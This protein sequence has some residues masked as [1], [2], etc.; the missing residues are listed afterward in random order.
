MHIIILDAQHTI[1]FLYEI[2]GDIKRYLDMRSRND[3][4]FL[5]ENAFLCY[6]DYKVSVPR[7]TNKVNYMEW[8]KLTNLTYQI[9]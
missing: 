5:L 6:I 1:N 2:N 9:Q 4:L 8:Y 7:M 3:L